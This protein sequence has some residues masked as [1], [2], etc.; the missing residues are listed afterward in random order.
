MKASSKRVLV[1]GH[2]LKT[3]PLELLKGIQEQQVYGSTGLAHLRHYSLI[4]HGPGL[5]LTMRRQEAHEG[6]SLFLLLCFAAIRM[7]I[8]SRPTV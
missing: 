1:G 6:V 2:A 3:V 8:L 4:F 5:Q 7:G